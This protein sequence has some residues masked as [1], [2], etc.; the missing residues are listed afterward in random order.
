MQVPLLFSNDLIVAKFLE[1]VAKPPTE[2]IYGV[3]KNRAHW[4]LWEF[5]VPETD[6]TQK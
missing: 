1:V 5:E 4:I 6:L 2:F 3:G